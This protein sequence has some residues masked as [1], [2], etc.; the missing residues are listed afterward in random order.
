LTKKKTVTLATAIRRKLE[1]R[2][3]PMR[4]GTPS[5]K[6]RSAIAN[7]WKNF[8]AKRRPISSS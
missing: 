3:S 8:D 4:F 6:P 1:T 5:R 7:E 2:V